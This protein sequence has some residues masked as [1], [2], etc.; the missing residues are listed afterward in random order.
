[1]IQISN[2]YSDNIQFM[3]KHNLLNNL[4]K[5]FSLTHARTHIHTHIQNE[6]KIYILPK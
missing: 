5:Y 1:M 4:F 2:D 6:K 3:S